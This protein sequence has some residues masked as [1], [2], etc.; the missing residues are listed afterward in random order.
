MKKILIM[1]MAV[2]MLTLIVAPAALAAGS[3]DY[4]FDETGILTSAQIDALNDKAAALSEKRKCEVYI[5]LTDLV[6]EEYAKTTDVL[7]AYVQAFFDWNDLG[8][9]KDKNGMVLLLETGDM[10]GE[11]DYHF[12]ANG[13]CESVFN[14]SARQEL[15]DDKIVPRFISAFNDGNFYNVA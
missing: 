5:W 7:E 15:L 6:P 13:R 14:N 12:Y 10:P 11:R 8:Y 3:G 9:G 4:V 1:L 2:I